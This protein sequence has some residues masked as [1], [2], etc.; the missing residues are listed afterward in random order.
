[1]LK[2]LHDTAYLLLLLVNPEQVMLSTP[3]VNC[4]YSYT[5][6]SQQ[7]QQHNCASGNNCAERS[8]RQSS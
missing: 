4:G 8:L 2:E 6:Y 3:E 1:M 7:E 5:R